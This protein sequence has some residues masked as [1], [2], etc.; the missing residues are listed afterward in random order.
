MLARTPLVPPTRRRFVHRRGSL[1]PVGPATSSPW[2]DAGHDR[3]SLYP[4]SALASLLMLRVLL[5]PTTGTPTPV[6]G[7]RRHCARNRAAEP[8]SSPGVLP[9]SRLRRRP[10]CSRRRG[11]ATGT[12]PRQPSRRLPHRE[13]NQSI[14][15]AT[16]LSL[17]FTA[18]DV[19][20]P[21]H[22]SVRPSQCSC[23]FT[24]THA[25]E[26]P[27]VPPRSL[28]PWPSHRHACARK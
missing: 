22:T 20:P 5:C 4:I 3:S 21:G 7:G 26:H 9:L 23:S 1:L 27:G 24:R 6:W 19:L 16:T 14:Q 2:V 18:E 17:Y 13:R 25:G 12:H 11:R 28:P 15:I 8:S 10:S